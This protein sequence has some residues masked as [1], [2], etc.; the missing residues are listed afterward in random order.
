MR[1]FLLVVEPSAVLFLV[2][3]IVAKGASH[4]DMRIQKNAR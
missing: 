3:S 4:D 2:S 1:G